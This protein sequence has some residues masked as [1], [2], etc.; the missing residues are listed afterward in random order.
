MGNENVTV[1]NCKVIKVDI[2]SNILRENGRD[3]P[4]TRTV[5][6]RPQRLRRNSA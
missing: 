6:D 3:Y 2:E 4:A 5:C 1:Q